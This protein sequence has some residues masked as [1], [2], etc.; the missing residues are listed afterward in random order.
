[1]KGYVNKQ[2]IPYILGKSSVNILNYSQSQYN[3]AR[4]NSSNKLF[5][6]MASGK[7]IISTV[8][9]G[10][11][12]LNKY[13]CGL[14]L[15]HNTA[16]DLAQAILQ[17]RNMPPEQY[18]TMSVN[19]RMAAKDFDVKTLSAKVIDVIEYVSEQRK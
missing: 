9:M 5:E 3:W 14:S 16:A 8:K 10:Y 13:Q 7:P 15:E 12:L 11:C 4:G 2:F 19:A 1:M 17:V 18:R 6:Y